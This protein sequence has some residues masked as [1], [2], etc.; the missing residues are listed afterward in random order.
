MLD[1]TPAERRAT[2][3]EERE[4]IRWARHGVTRVVHVLNTAN[5]RVL[6]FRELCT[7]HPNLVSRGAT[8]DRVRRMF[9]GVT[10][11]LRTWHHTLAGGPQPEI[12]QGQFRHTR[13]GQL[14]RARQAA[15]PG[16]A[17]VPAWVC[18]T[19]PQTGAIRVTS[20]PAA[21]PTDASQSELCQTICLACSDD[22]ESVTDEETVTDDE[23][24]HV[25]GQRGEGAHLGR[26][27][28]VLAEKAGAFRHAALGPQGAPPVPD[29]RLLEWAM[30][31][32]CKPA[33][34]VCLAYATTKDVRQTLLAQTWREPRSFTTRYA[35]LFEGLSTQERSAR[36]R[37]VAEALTHPAIPEVER[38]HLYVTMHH[39]H[40]QGGIKLRDRG[41]Q[42][43]CATCLRAGDSQE[44]TAVHVAHGCPTARAVWAAVARTWQEATSEP[45]DVTDPTLTVLGLRPRQ[46]SGGDSR[47]EARHRAREPAWRLLHAVTLLKLHQARTRAHMAYHDPKGPREPR[48]AKPKHILRAIRQR[49]ARMVCYEHAK[50][51]HSTQAEP[52]AGPRQ[53]AWHTFH[54]HW[55]A[56]GVASMAKGGRPRLH[57]LAAAPPVSHAAPGSTHIRV[58]AALTPAKGKR[59]T[60]SAWALEAHDVGP[61]GEM[62]ERLRASGAIATAATHP[63]HGQATVAKRHTWQVAMQVAADRALLYAAQLRR[64][65]RRVT[66]S[67]PSATT[68]RDLQ[69]ARP[70]EARPRTS[71]RDIASN[72]SRK[73]QLLGTQ[74]TIN[75]DTAVTPQRLQHAAGAAAHSGDI[76]MQVSVPGRAMHAIPFWDELRTWDPGD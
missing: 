24:P 10:A 67:L 40:W 66:I 59:P 37:R 23:D 42:R 32:T 4:M 58:G 34:H 41:D 19:E 74:V 49:C 21:L 16:D 38:H 5:T 71:H 61:D 29:P 1:A 17:T 13:T 9:E 47:A 69:P 62:T 11:N 52:R 31:E 43:L 56:T 12:Q 76:R 57:L 70:G 68:A 50:A 72:N 28:S 25:A 30:P 33:R 36:L 7:R 20:D 60:A 35:T 8:R 53:G 73:L 18:E 44:D 3:A 26:A 75:V 27:A 54:K 39:G 63:A 51:V 48:Q 14:L 22:D 2:P 46:P 55:L 65:G 64:K 15:R 6:T 45:L